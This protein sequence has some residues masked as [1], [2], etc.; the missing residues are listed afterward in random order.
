MKNKI[1]D[2]DSFLAV[3]QHIM[4]YILAAYKEAKG[5]GQLCALLIICVLNYKLFL[6]DMLEV[7]KEL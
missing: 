5:K 6:E 4:A 7:H 3:Q 2:N 1:A